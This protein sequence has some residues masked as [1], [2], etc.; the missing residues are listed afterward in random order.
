[1]SRVLRAT[2]VYGLGSV[3]GRVVSFVMLP[4]YTHYIDPAEYAKL[5]LVLMT[6]DILGIAVSAGTT[7]GFMRFFYKAETSREKHEVVFSALALNFGL[8]LIGSVVLFVLA[9][10]LAALVLSSAMDAV[11]FKI[12]AGC[13]LLES[14]IGVPLL[15]MQAEHKAVLFSTATLSR[16]VL[17]AGLNLVFLIPLGMGV[18]G[19]LIST[20]IAHTILGI[21]GTAWAL[22]RTGWAWSG[23]MARRLR[24]FG[25]PYQIAT[26]G[27]FILTFGDR[28]VLK[29][30]RP[31]SEV[32]LYAF[33]Y[34]FGFLLWSVA[35]APFFQTWTPLRFQQ[36]PGARL[37]RDAAYSQGFLNLNLVMVSG[38][39]A[40]TL[41][42]HPALAW[43]T[44]PAYH[45]SAAIV[46]IV[47]A[48]Y[49][50]QSWSD[51]MQFG[52]DASEQTRY[53]TYA[54]WGATVVTVALY[55]ALI[56][57]FGA[58]GAA[59][60]TLLGFL[61]RFALTSYYAGRLTP[62][63]YDWS[64]VLRLLVAGIVVGGLGIL[65]APEGLTAQFALAT[66]LG[67]A[68]LAIVWRAVLSEHDRT[69]FTTIGRKL[70]E[71]L[72]P[73]RVAGS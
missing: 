31:L 72:I 67:V 13:F 20:L 49:V 53:A 9:A 73:A 5:Q 7:A 33:G 28:Y 47:A 48:A 58:Q 42:V 69:L 16:T 70:V 24:Q 38:A 26:A 68:Y 50:V 25:I 59:L 40:L 65:A 60:A 11:L 64:P 54:F 52:I 17:S 30:S 34:Q 1:M 29:A 56:P 39:V 8:N 43:L 51:A 2:I 35:A 6:V 45:A 18:R 66:G 37:E 46:P 21:A 63:T 71:R 27:S 62:I 4:I 22:R 57:P 61:A 14:L 23:E 36:L 32:G 44:A 41:V 55:L 10:P 12:L 3:L 19:I 15:L